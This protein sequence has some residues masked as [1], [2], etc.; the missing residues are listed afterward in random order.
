VWA[1]LVKQ[2]GGDSLGVLDGNPDV[3]A[4]E[5]G[6]GQGDP[7]PCEETAIKEGDSSASFD[8]AKDALGFYVPHCQFLCELFRQ[9][10]RT[11]RHPT[12]KRSWNMTAGKGSRTGMAGAC[13]APH[14]PVCIMECSLVER[15]NSFLRS[16]TE[17]SDDDLE[18]GE[19]FEESDPEYR[20]SAAVCVRDP[21]GAAAQLPK[22]CHPADVP[23][24]CAY[25]I[26]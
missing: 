23:N 2:V 26:A 8:S 4:Y 16:S 9:S 19:N 15:D 24:N 1:T 14:L 25:F 11:T 13:L 5:R 21:M 10:I 7:T 6:E 18:R 22:L 17:W 3:V 12:R 20:P